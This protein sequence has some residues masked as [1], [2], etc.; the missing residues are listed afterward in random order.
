MATESI[1]RIILSII[2]LIVIIVILSRFRVN[3]GKTPPDDSLEVMEKRLEN[4]EI[5]QEEYDEAKR[6]RGK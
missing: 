4:G 1:I 6:R 2:V 5:T 3:K